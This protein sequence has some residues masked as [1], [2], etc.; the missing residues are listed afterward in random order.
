MKLDDFDYTLP[1][2]LIAQYPL[3][4]R[5]K[6]RM[7]VLNPS[8]SNIE[9]DFFY[10]FTKYLKKGDTLV[11]NNTKV[12][13]A[14]LLGKRKTGAAIEIFLL[15]PLS[16]NNWN[17]LIK[18]SRRLKNGEIIEIAPQLSVKITNKENNEVE[19]IFKGDLY[20]ILDKIGK[21]PL[22]PY[23]SR[24][25][26]EEDREDYQTVFAKI[27]GSVAAPT[28][29]LHFDNN[30]LEHIKK[31]GVNICYVT[32]NVGLGTFL[33]VKCENILEHKMHKES[34]E[35]SSETAD[36]INNTKG[37][38]IAIGTTVV[39][40]LEATF[41]K[42]GKIIPTKEDTD[43]FIYPPYEFKV[44]DKLLTNFHLPKS[45]LLML[46]C[47]FCKDNNFVLEAYNSAVQKQYRFFSY[48]DC[49]LIGNI[50][51]I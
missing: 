35:I 23:I 37:D 26:N 31:M 21:V 42:Y 43:I 17:V 19:L 22:P 34:F 14:R 16:N 33:P 11:L 50:K 8:K 12:I 27:K 48:G 47:A 32:L 39:R 20:E 46:V 15:K 28:A 38:I 3:K 25:A 45:T 9:D 10:N 6:A 1:K 29:G 41:Q 13:P 2:N 7:M 4:D 44:V 49:M 40:T 51:N 24:C 18:N 36:I 30:M 5:V